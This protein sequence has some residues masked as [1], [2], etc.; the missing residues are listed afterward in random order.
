MFYGRQNKYLKRG[1][2]GLCWETLFLA[3]RTY[4]T[5]YSDV[6]TLLVFFS[7]KDEYEDIGMTTWLLLSLVTAQIPLDAWQR[8][9]CFLATRT[10]STLSTFFVSIICLPHLFPAW[11]LQDNRTIWDLQFKSQVEGFSVNSTLIF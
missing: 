5:T 11:G 4:Q 1:E 8:I 3:S 2:A 9:L 10:M 7:S 6:K